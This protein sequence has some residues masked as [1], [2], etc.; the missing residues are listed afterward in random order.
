M[1]LVAVLDGGNLERSRAGDPEAP[2]RLEGDGVHSWSRGH[3]VPWLF[4]APG[5][6][7]AARCPRP[8]RQLPRAG[9]LSLGSKAHDLRPGTPVARA[10]GHPGLSSRWAEPALRGS[11]P[12][13]GPDSLWRPHSGSTGPEKDGHP[14]ARA[15]TTLRRFPEDVYQWLCTLPDLTPSEWSPLA[16]PPVALSAGLGGVWLPG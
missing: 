4:T 7:L 12:G 1:S 9:W 14:G 3:Q 11:S 6:K 15:V 10:S 13:R 2:P 8:G 5:S 16:S